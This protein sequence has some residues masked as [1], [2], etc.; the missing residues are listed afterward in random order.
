[1]ERK[2]KDGSVVVDGSDGR[3]K[4]DGDVVAVEARY[5]RMAMLYDD[6]RSWK[7]AKAGRN[8]AQ[9]GGRGKRGG[10]RRVR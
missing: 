3:A 5:R 10:R 4:V 9:A 1:M 7:G 8:K 6:R 2:G